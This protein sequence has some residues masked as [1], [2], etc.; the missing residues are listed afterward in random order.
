[1]AFGKQDAVNPH[2]RAG[3]GARN[4]L[5]GVVSFCD[6]GATL[7]EVARAH[8]IEYIKFTKG[9]MSYHDMVLPKW[10]EQPRQFIILWG[11]T[12]SGKSWGA[13][14]I[15]GSDSYFKGDY[16][17]SSHISFENYDGQKWIWL[18]EYKG[19]GLFC[20]DLK[21]MTDRG[22]CRLRGRGCTKKGLHHGV[23][24][25]S[26]S[27]P[28]TWFP[29]ESEEDM[30]ALLRRVTRLYQCNRD[31]WC[32]QLSGNVFKNPCPFVSAAA[33]ARTFASL[34]RLPTSSSAAQTSGSATFLLNNKKRKFTKHFPASDVVDLR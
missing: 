2:V 27:D 22:E 31:Q 15:I 25:T 8:P 30:S 29:N 14:Q 11:Q 17:N 20:D 32:N 6:R 28:S 21:T 4:D 9:I 18:E 33:P 26:Q 24:I 12:G 1:V 13:S 34:A 23:I 7:E 3:K 16:N 10:E 19:L 5:A